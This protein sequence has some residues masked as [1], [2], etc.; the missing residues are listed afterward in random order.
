[1]VADE[2]EVVVYVI[3]QGLSFLVVKH[4]VLINLESDFLGSVFFHLRYAY[5]VKIRIFYQFAR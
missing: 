4:A 1:M 5:V 3:L 2:L